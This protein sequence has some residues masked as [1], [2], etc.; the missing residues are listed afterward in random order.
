MHDPKTVAH[1]IYL[2]KKRKK[3]GRYRSPL[4]TI[5][6]VDPE[7]D[8][9]DDSCGWFM[10]C[11]HGDP[12]MLKKIRSSI[13]FDFDRTFKSDDSGTTYYTGYF[14]PNSGM[15]NMSVHGIVL[16]MF[17]KAAWQFFK[18]NKKKHT[19]WMKDNLYEIMQFAENPVDSLRDEI[20]GTFR[21]GTGSKWK[22]EEALDH[23][24]SIIYGWLLRSTRKWYQHPKWHIRHWQ[25]QFHPFQRIK[26]RY[27]D[28]CCVCGKRGFKGSSAYGNWEGTKIWHSHCD[29][30]AK[31]APKPP[32][33]DSE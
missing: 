17:N 5:W 14:S 7:K 10:R 1:E 4:L 33:S 28:K 26:R 25:V 22:R 11:R 21:I 12:E 13:E 27:W 23:Y 15:P 30:T 9:T 29:K 24:S 16:D 18:Y 6:H 8:G 20:N 32:E 19:K 2:G 31:L 3:N